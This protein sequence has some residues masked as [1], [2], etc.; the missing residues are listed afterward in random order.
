MEVELSS[1]FLK[2][3]RL[4]S[5]K[6]KQRLSER[7]EWFRKNP[8]DPRLK[9]HALTGKLKGMYSFSITHGK[10]VTY[11]LID[12]FTALFIDAG[13]HEDVYR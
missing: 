7:T 1:R 6:E 12:D 5:N 3:A 10:R 9:A 2:R 11:V 4:L 13:S 8:N